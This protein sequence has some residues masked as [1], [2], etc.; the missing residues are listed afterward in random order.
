MDAHHYIVPEVDIDGVEPAF[1]SPGRGILP[2]F[3]RIYRSIE[4]SKRSDAGCYPS[5]VAGPGS[6]GVF[7]HRLPDAAYSDPPEYLTVGDLKR[8]PTKHLFSIELNGEIFHCDRGCIH[9]A[10]PL[11]APQVTKRQA[12]DQPLI[13]Y[14][15]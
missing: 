1:R 2:S 8:N 9:G 12:T 6:G 5:Q 10:I 15:P 13:R 14:G 7:W 11:I 4:G 3:G